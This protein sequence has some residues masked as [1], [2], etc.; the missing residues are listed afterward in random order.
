MDEM[1]K[2]HDRMKKLGKELTGLKTS[3]EFTENV[4][5]EKVKK[6]GEEHMNL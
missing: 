5:E 4:V 1:K 6:L 2:T 3:L